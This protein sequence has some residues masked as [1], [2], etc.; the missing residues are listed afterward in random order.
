MYR[1]QVLNHVKNY[2]YV[3][4]VQDY[5]WRR[6]WGENVNR[7]ADRVEALAKA[8]F[9]P[10]M[11]ID[12]PQFGASDRI[13]VDP[14]GNIQRHPCVFARIFD[15]TA[16][17][18]NIARDKHVFIA[19]SATPY[20]I[21]D[22]KRVWKVPQ[23][24]GP[25]Y[26]RFNFFAGAKIDE[27]AEI[28][29]PRIL[30][31]S[32]FANEIGV[33]FLARVNLRAFDSLDRF[34]KMRKRLNYQG[35]WQQ[36]REDALMAIS[37][38][39]INLRERHPGETFGVCMRT[40]NNNVKADDILGTLPIRNEFDVVQYY[41]LEATGKSVKQILAERDSDRQEKPF[42]LMVTS[43]ARMG[44]AFPSAVKYFFEFTE[45]FTDLNS[46]MQGLIGRACGYGKNST[47]IL[48]ERNT[49]MM[50][51]VSSINGGYIMDPSRHTI[52]VGG[53]RR[54]RPTVI[55]TV[56]RRAGDVKLERFFKQ[57]DSE[58]VNALVKQPSTNL[59]VKKRDSRRT[60][61]VLRIAEETA[62]FDYLESPEAHGLYY[63][64]FQNFQIARRGDKVQNLSKLGSFLE[65]R[66]DDAGNCRFAFREWKREAH[67]G[68]RARGRSGG[69]DDA[70]RDLEH[71][72]LEPQILLEKYDPAT[73]EAIRDFDSLSGARI[74]GMWRAYA[75]VL[76]LMHPVQ[77]FIAGD[78]AY[79]IE[80]SP[81]SEYMLDEERDARQREVA[82]RQLAAN[83]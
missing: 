83:N 46:M 16:K 62:L 47:V 40:L 12:E 58:I 10:L 37:Q 8:G 7:I 68:L 50:R 44:D 39:L 43:R 30:S 77:E 72:H 60:G 66:A 1:D 81:Y 21:H 24:L 9:T 34:N 75:V 82:R 54:G 52:V 80:T 29:P 3:P 79:P 25:G 74:N 36:Y 64:N 15:E 20:E 57:V 4:K 53:K 55:L 17:R 78:A 31:F 48:S 67:T 38:M 61:P 76:P 69:D 56:V 19:L 28:N 41:G 42:L 49:L 59:R 51:A 2:F 26:S 27:A 23:R 5:I 18:L 6:A 22:L 32:E 71:E 65:Y 33:P 14:S 70:T 45:K 35:E 63:E 11:I 13:E 73:G